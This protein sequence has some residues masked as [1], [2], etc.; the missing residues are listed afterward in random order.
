M[1]TTN[2]H[3]FFLGT[4]GG[5]TKWREDRKKSGAKSLRE[6][7]KDKGQQHRATKCNLKFEIQ[8][9]CRVFFLEDIVKLQDNTQISSPPNNPPKLSL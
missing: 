6:A 3:P 1:E 9:N 8:Y 2:E 5:L 4:L 7:R